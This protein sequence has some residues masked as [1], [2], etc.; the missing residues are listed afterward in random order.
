MPLRS[1]APVLLR[2]HA[3]P[4]PAAPIFSPPPGFDS[5]APAPMPSPTPSAWQNGNELLV[6]RLYV[7]APPER[8]RQPQVQKMKEAIQDFVQDEYNTSRPNVTLTVFKSDTLL[9]LVIEVP[10]V[11]S[12]RIR[13]GMTDWVEDG[14]LTSVLGLDVGLVDEQIGAYDPVDDS[15]SGASS[16]SPPRPVLE[17]PL[18]KP[19][20]TPS[21]P[22]PRSEYVYLVLQL[23][24]RTITP[25]QFTDQLHRRLVK[26][27]ASN[28]GLEAESFHLTIVLPGSVFA[29]YTVPVRRDAAESVSTKLEKFVNSGSMSLRTRLPVSLIEGQVQHVEATPNDDGGGGGGGAGGRGEDGGGADD[30]EDAGSTPNWV[31]GMVVGL[32]FAALLAVAAVGWVFRDRL[33]LLRTYMARRRKHQEYYAMAGNAYGYFGAGDHAFVSEFV[34][35]GAGASNGSASDAHLQR[36]HGGGGGTEP[37]RIDEELDDAARS[38]SS[39]LSATPDAID[40]HAGGAAAVGRRRYR[41]RSGGGGDGGDGSAGDRGEHG[42]VVVAAGEVTHSPCADPAA[43]AESPVAPPPPPPLPVMLR[44]SAA[45]HSNASRQYLDRP[46][47]HKWQIDRGELTVHEVIGAGGFGTVHRAAW[48]GTEVAVK[49]AYLEKRLSAEEEEEFLAECDMMANLRHPCILQFLAAVVE[50]PNLCLVIE[51]MPRGSLFELLHG[52]DAPREPLPWKRRLAM[53]QDAARGMTYLHACRPPIIHRDLKSMNC[54]V[55]DT[56]RIKISD[57]GLSRAKHK[58]F[59]TSRIVGGT[60]EWTAPEIIRN[61]RHDEKC[62]VYSFGVVAWEMITRR[63]PFDGLKPMQVLAAV[64]FRGARLGLPHVGDASPLADKR[65]FV[66]LIARCWREHADARPTMAAVYR[67]LVEIGHMVGNWTAAAA[68]AEGS[69]G[70]NNGGDDEEEEEG[71]RAPSSS[72]SSP[73]ATRTNA[74]GEASNRARSGER[75]KRSRRASGKRPALASPHSRADAASARR[76]KPARASADGEQ[77]PAAATKMLAAG[78]HT[79]THAG[80][81]RHGASDYIQDDADAAHDS[82]SSSHHRPSPAPR[83]K[84]APLDMSGIHKNTE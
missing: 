67:E 2:T 7:D 78:S 57:F 10:S 62:D 50:P 72:S 37:V 23:Y 68:A 4:I 19:V 45:S 69:G 74:N 43:N 54:L 33:P 28:S 46:P 15:T 79:P 65:A 32:I 82:S 3:Q 56:M 5:D 1:P 26:G 35:N 25:A 6:A 31:I 84:L 71:E 83:P 16:S 13:A 21:L 18:A 47:K 58:T 11:L 14:G 81:G 36:A 49:R 20:P 38:A 63:V 41:I 76:K 59:L 53:M 44:S 55:S 66:D 22:A 24:I 48:R 73:G 61:E 52:G 75:A 34:E 40:A 60:P 30:S 17:G 51:L 29:T 77:R 64:G 70:S 42:A 8:V 27:L 39:P 80:D 12:T 9:T